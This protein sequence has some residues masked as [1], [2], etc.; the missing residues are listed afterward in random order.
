[1]AYPKAIIQ[2]T[3]AGKH[4][5]DLLLANLHRRVQQQAQAARLPSLPPSPPPADPARSPLPPAPIVPPPLL[6]ARVLSAPVAPVDAPATKSLKPPPEPNMSGPSSGKAPLSSDEK[7]DLTYIHMLMETQHN[8]MIQSQQDCAALAERMTRFE[9]ASAQCITWLEEAIMLL[10]T[11]R[12]DLANRQSLS[13]A[14]PPSGRID[15]QCFRNA[16]GP[17]Y[18]GPFHDHLART[19]QTIV[20]F[21]GGADAIDGERSPTIPDLEL[22]E[23]VLHGLP[24]EL[25]ALVKNHQVLLTRPFQYSKFKS[26]TQLFYEGLPKKSVAKRRPIGSSTPSTSTTSSCTSCNQTIWR[27]HSFLDSQGKCHHCKKCRGSTFGSCPNTLNCAYVEIPAS[28]VTPPEPSDY[29]PPKAGA[30]SPSGAGKPTQGPAGRAPSKASVAALDDNGE[31][32]K[33][34]VAS[35]AAFA[36]VDEELCLAREDHPPCRVIF[37][38]TVS[39]NQYP[40]GSGQKI[41]Y[42]GCPTSFCLHYVV[43]SA[44]GVQFPRCLPT[45]WSN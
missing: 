40:S 26:R 11:K 30:P 36:A 42:S 22:A 19:L 16:D 37:P 9:E 41:G 6:P 3:N 23:A 29:K 34:N 17:I 28:F 15:L 35:V 12:E 31:F 44:L 14:P 39:S 32:P 38:V 33:L 10:S 18:T 4:R 24:A 20:N 5:A 7:A 43:S 8:S 27:V 45:C 25:K 13:S 2:A 1:M 21:E